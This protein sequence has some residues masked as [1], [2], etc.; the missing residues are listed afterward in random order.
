MPDTR[1]QAILAALLPLLPLLFPD[2]DDQDETERWSV[3]TVPYAMAPV[4]QY[5]SASFAVESI[6]KT[7]APPA[8]EINSS[9]TPEVLA[10]ALTESWDDAPPVLQAL[11]AI[12]RNIL[13]QIYGLR[14]SVPLG[15]IH[16]GVT[17]LVAVLLALVAQ[18]WFTRRKSNPPEDQPVVPQTET[19]Q[20]GV[21]TSQLVDNVIDSSSG[22]Q[23]LRLVLSLSVD[24]NSGSLPQPHS[25]CHS[26]DVLHDERPPIPS[27]SL[28]NVPTPPRCQT[29]PVPLQITASES[30]L[31]DLSST[32][33]DETSILPVAQSLVLPIAP[34]LGDCSTPQPARDSGSL[35]RSPLIGE[36]DMLPPRSSWSLDKA[37]EKS[38]FEVTVQ[39]SALPA[40]GFC[41]TAPSST[42][43]SPQ[44]DPQPEPGPQMQEP[45]STQ[46]Q[47]IVQPRFF[48]PPPPIQLSPE[49][50]RAAPNLVT[51]E[52]I[53]G[54]PTDVSER[55]EEPESDHGSPGT[56]RACWFSAIRGRLAIVDDR[57]LTYGEMNARPEDGVMSSPETEAPEVFPLMMPQPLLAVVGPPPLLSARDSRGLGLDL[58]TDG[59][60]PEDSDHPDEDEDEDTISDYASKVIASDDEGYDHRVSDGDENDGYVPSDSPTRHL[61][62]SSP[63]S[64]HTVVPESED[65]QSIDDVSPSELVQA[66]VDI[67]ECPG[68]L[69]LAVLD[70]AE[71]EDYLSSSSEWELV[72]A[73]SRGRSPEP[74]RSIATSIPDAAGKSASIAHSEPMHAPQSSTKKPSAV[75]PIPASRTRTVSRSVSR[76]RRNTSV[77]RSLVSLKSS[78]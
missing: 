32:T 72:E 30:S 36:E 1:L 73:P 28:H 59:E 31:P 54:V 70:A 65:A 8:R 69:E 34:S 3:S 7:R 38:P 43:T 66:S 15:W 21:D 58:A 22:E 60:S 13:S 78:Y 45:P 44:Q 67:Q 19:I 11:E 20:E 53:H 57:G 37:C 9:I 62:S 18:S 42:T 63:S 49:Y 61:R 51:E 47:P 39:S 75:V 2:F 48:L 29:P 33:V 5:I 12:C 46:P 77:S 56:P 71:V 24:G 26:T 25:P 6:A 41:T 16:W 64:I 74:V 4:P 17:L 76:P 35:P 10:D 27:T 14:L 50:Y 68:A 55:T 52:V 40:K 23:S